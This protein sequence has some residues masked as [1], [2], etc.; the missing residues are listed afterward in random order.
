M[1]GEYYLRFC[2]LRTRLPCRPPPSSKSVTP[3]VNFDPRARDAAPASLPLN[4]SPLCFPP[5][6]DLLTSM[7]TTPSFPYEGAGGGEKGEGRLLSGIG[8]GRARCPSA[9]RV[10]PRPHQTSVH[11]QT[12]VAVSHP[13]LPLQIPSIV[14]PGRS[15]P[16]NC[17]HPPE[18]QIAPFGA[19]ESIPEPNTN[20]VFVAA[21]GERGRRRGKY[22]Y[23]ACIHRLEC[24]LGS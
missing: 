8:L 15:P 1:T 6:L 9:R 18:L 10:A 4:A 13:S 3:L 21:R 14:D 7:T 23:P 24:G 20:L 16:I 17:T 19:T 12:K 2:R 5:S 22:E 11:K